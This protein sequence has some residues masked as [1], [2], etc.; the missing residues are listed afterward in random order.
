MVREC[1]HIDCKGDRLLE[2]NSTRFSIDLVSSRKLCGA[3][4]RVRTN[5]MSTPTRRRVR[6]SIMLS[7]TW[8][9]ARTTETQHLASSLGALRAPTFA[10]TIHGRR[11]SAVGLVGGTSV[12]VETLCV[13]A[14]PNTPSGWV[15][16][17]GC[18]QVA[19]MSGSI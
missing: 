4:E 13:G 17:S 3:Q 7:Q 10:A 14:L 6:R 5:Y 19:A 12:S 16:L 9:Q 11:G 15:H 8:W 18:M 1:R 2:L